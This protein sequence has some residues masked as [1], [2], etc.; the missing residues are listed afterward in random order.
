MHERLSDLRKPPTNDT[1]RND[2]A[3]SKG[4]AP[5]SAAG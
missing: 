2:N 5:S 1:R 3:A 4:L